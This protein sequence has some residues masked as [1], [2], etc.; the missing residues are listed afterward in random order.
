MSQFEFIMA[1]VSLIMALALAQG[2]RGLSEILVSE[3]RYSPHTLWVVAYVLMILLGWWGF[4]DF[5]V[6]QQWKLTTYLVVLTLPTILYTGI[7]L[8]VPST[9]ESDIDWR[10]QFLRV[11][12]LFFGLGVAMVLLAVFVNIQ[13][14]D[15]PSMHPYRLAQAVYITIF[16]VGFFAEDERV[17]RSLPVFFIASFTVSLLLVRMNI[18]ALV[19]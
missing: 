4:W 5:N 11:R 7:H 10:A 12:R 13:Y 19:S 14:F 17:Q 2:L 6:V 16:S 1:M 9:R 8:L 18:G 3:K 15:T